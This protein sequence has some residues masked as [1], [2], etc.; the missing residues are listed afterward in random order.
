MEPSAYPP[1]WY[2]DPVAGAPPGQHRYFTGT[3]WTEHVTSPPGSVPE[4]P[5]RRGLKPAL[6]AAALVL[7]VLIV[8]YLIARPASKS[9]PATWDPQ[10][11]PIAHQV[12]SLRGLSFDHPVPVRY[13]PDDKF[14]K[15][16]GVDTEKL[17]GKARKQ[18][19]DLGATLRAFGLIDLET[20]LVKSFDTVNRAGVLAYYDPAA[21]EIVVRGVGPLDL[22]RKATLAHEL[23]HVLQDQHFDLQG[24]R[25]EAATSKTG[26]TGALTALVEGDAERIKYRY[27]ASLPKAD[28]DA[29]D[30]QQDKDGASVDKKVADAA[31]I[32]KID[33]SAPYVFGPQVLRALTAKGGNAAVNDA[34]RRSTPSDE[35]FLNP[36]AALTDPNPISVS[37]PSLV[38]G[39]H[40][41]G[42]PD[43][44]G[45]FD[46]FV[47]LASR[48]D[49]QRAL[50]AS[51]AWAGDRVVTYKSHGAVCVK[52]TIASRTRAGASV[53]GDTLEAWAKT[54]PSARVTRD[55]DGE[56][57][58]VVSCDAGAVRAPDAK[59]LEAA[60][61]LVSGRNSLVTSLLGEHVPPAVS[62]CVS[63]DLVRTPLFISTLTAR[64]RVHTR[65]AGGGPS[66]DAHAAQA[67]R[68]RER[69]FLGSVST[70][71]LIVLR[72]AREGE[73]MAAVAHRVGDHLVVD[74]LKSRGADQVQVG[75]AVEVAPVH[76]RAEPALRVVILR[77]VRGA[78][79]QQCPPP[80]T[81]HPSDLAEHQ[82]MIRA[83]DVDDRVVRDA[84]VEGRVGE[85]EPR[86]IPLHGRSVRNVLASEVE[87]T[88]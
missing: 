36:V 5:R 13:V 43:T 74:D 49:R 18:L 16:V 42:K 69:F 27:L 17:S 52:A 9:Y 33:L 26:S 23:V 20:D 48:L 56:R 58:T 80:W 46:L 29:Y 64:W 53:L 75:G 25:R 50:D 78:D 84:P 12:E 83:R 87:L 61:R 30:A 41:L 65:R 37:T 70:D 10:V 24:L 51:D 4:R 85:G 55:L 21:E 54:M 34:L 8:G 88:A 47:V 2:P 60:F 73:E 3:V 44:L 63:H 6:I 1:G 59:R 71:Q 15:G 22:Q 35:I 14:R 39:D 31:E 28:R 66:R 38:D 82:R 79:A 68:R 45:P 77:Q 40:Q 57:V 19:D 76:R 72:S 32:V 62:E 7:V 11:A 81:E 86:E 67:V